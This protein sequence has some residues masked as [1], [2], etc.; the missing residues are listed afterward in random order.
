MITTRASRN[1]EGPNPSTTIPEHYTIGDRLNWDAP[2]IVVRLWTELPFWLMVDNARVAVTYGDHEFKIAIHDD[3]YELFFGES[4][5]SRMSVGYR[6][7]RKEREDLTRSTEVES[8]P[9]ITMC[10]GR[11]GSAMKSMEQI[12]DLGQID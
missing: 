9:R 12:S 10:S 3:Y 2:W 7:S 1:H 11:P 4:T 6:G 8:R 5:D